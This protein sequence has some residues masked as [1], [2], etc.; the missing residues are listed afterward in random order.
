MTAK[1]WEAAEAEL[2][3]VLVE[4]GQNDA[5]IVAKLQ[6]VN[7]NRTYKAVQRLRQRRGWH[8]QVQPSGFELHKPLTFQSNR[9]LLWADSHAPFHDAPWMNRVIDLALRWDVEDCAIVGDLIDFSAISSYGREIGVEMGAEMRSAKQ[10]VRT[11]ARAFRRKLLIGGNHEKRLVR[12]LT[13]AVSLQ[14]AVEMLAD[15][16]D[17]AITTNLKWFWLD[18]GGQAFRVVHPKNYSRVR[19]RVATQLAARYQSHIIA[20]HS[21]H[22]GQTRDDSGQFWAIDMGCCVDPERV[23]WLQQDMS[24]TPKSLLGAV[25]VIDGTPILLGPKNIA[26]YEGLKL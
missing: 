25:I 11:I 13:D 23:L 20:G 3:R 24:T 22:W 18:S 19:T 15:E 14:E 16:A 2:V 10:I 4:Q 6:S 12:K 5:E 26:F 21:H 9:I 7:I 17:G 8:A 1:R